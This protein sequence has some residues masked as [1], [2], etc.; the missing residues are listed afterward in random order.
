MLQVFFLRLFHEQVQ[1]LTRPEGHSACPFL[2][3]RI[4]RRSSCHHIPDAWMPSNLFYIAR[5]S[6][7]FSLLRLGHVTNMGLPTCS[8]RGRKKFADARSHRT[9]DKA[10]S[11]ECFG[12]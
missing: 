3:L 10:S 9:N 5:E 4:P 8:S 7:R 2:T 11:A 12:P 6:C 1:Q